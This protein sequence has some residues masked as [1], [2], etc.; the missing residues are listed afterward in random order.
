LDDFTIEETDVTPTAPFEIG[1]TDITATSAD[2]NWTRNAEDFEFKYREKAFFLDDSEEGSEPWTT[3]GLGFWRTLT[4]T[5]GNNVNH[6]TQSTNILYTADQNG[7]VIQT[8]IVPVDTWRVS[9]KVSLTGTLS[10]LA[11]YYNETFDESTDT[12]EVLVSTTVNNNCDA[13]TPIGF[14]SHTTTED[15]FN[16]NYYS[17]SLDSYNGQEGYIAFRHKSHNRSWLILDDIAIYRTTDEWTTLTTT[18]NNVR[19]TGLEPTTDYEFQMRSM[20]FDNPSDWTD[21]KTFTTEDIK[22]LDGKADNAM[23][24][25]AIADG[26]KHDVMIQDYSLSS[27]RGEWNT[28]CLPFDVT[29]FDDTDGITFSGTP[30]EGA[31]VKELTG[32]DFSS[33]VLTMN[34]NEVT[35]VEA[36]KPYIVQWP[37]GADLVI[38]N[39]NEWSTFVARVATGE[40]F[41]GKYVI[42]DGDINAVLM[43]GT[44]EHPFCG[45]FDGNG[46]TLNVNIDQ[47]GVDYAAPFQYIN[48]AT[49]RNVKVTGSVSGGQYCAGIAGKAT[50]GTNSI[51]NCWMSASVTSQGNIGGVLGHGTTSSTTISNCYL[52]GTLNGENIGI[53]CG[54]GY[55]G[56]SHTLNTCWAN[57]TYN[58]NG[59]AVNL[60][61]ADGTT[62]SFNNCQHNDKRISQ[63]TYRYNDLVIILTLEG[64]SNES[65]Y[66]SFLGSQWG[67]N[68]K[69]ELIIRPSAEMLSSNIQNPTFKDVVTNTNSPS[70]L[71]L[72]QGEFGGTY[73]PV[74]SLS[75]VLLD[76][77]NPGN[78][79]F[80]AAYS[81]NRASLGDD[82]VDWYSDATLTSPATVIPFDADGNVTLYA[83]RWVELADDAD[84]SGT[85][86]SIVSTGTQRDRVVL[87]KDRTIYRDDDWNTLCL[88]F[89]MSEAQI[90]A[91][92]LVGVTIMELDG[93]K[94]KLT[95]D[96]KLTLSFKDAF[97]IEAGRPYIV[98]WKQP[99]LVI[100]N[101][102]DWDNFATAVN[103][104]TTYAGKLVKL[105]ASIDA[106]T[107]VGTADHPF[108]GIF[109]GNGYTL[110]L[111][112][113]DSDAD[114]AAPFRY[115]N[116]ATIRNLKVTGS[117]KGGQYCAGIVGAAIDGTNRI[118]NCWMSANV[119]GEN[120]NIGGVLGNGTSSYT[121]ISNC[122]LNSTLNGYG[123]GVFCGGGSAD[124]TLILETCWT[125]GGYNYS[126]NLD[127]S[128]GEINLVKTDGGTT[129]IYNCNHNIE[130]ITQGTYSLL[131]IIGENSNDSSLA[132]FLGNQWT[133]DNSGKLKLRPSA[134]FDDTPIENPKFTGVT[135]VGDDPTPVK[136]SGVKFIGTYSPVILPVGDHYNLF[137]GT[138]NTLFWPSAAHNDANGYKLNSCRAYFNT[139]TSAV[140]EFRLIFGDE[141]YDAQSVED[142][143]LNN[144]NGDGAWYDLSGRKLDGRPTKKGLYI[145]GGRK[146]VVN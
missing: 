71:S 101:A 3:T 88:P 99:T 69:G 139:G 143:R 53:F 36:G 112:I 110:N 138:N 67:L 104:G 133:T 91:S 126:I 66:V 61:T 14:I 82:F 44:P 86:A 72:N 70:T 5:V 39:G 115:I 136:F 15:F 12:C 117:V 22:L 51:R 97:S 114:Y 79:A 50:G 81:Y 75:D 142:V 31:T 59:G 95:A 52:T 33:D 129:I 94:S 121:T 19:L 29:D 124:G 40:T 24:I 87:L 25:A 48:G 60:V 28:L 64:G 32:S 6:V 49:I 123:I 76:A 8:D 116:G 140:R 45:T 89:S 132:N 73:S 125:M 34:F 17:C 21:I 119:T 63:G 68:S 27:K 41:A 100:K 92:P 137:L 55:A 128:G 30:L 35:A 144:E 105:D 18:E 65:Q 93:S 77:H 109:D 113:D 127:G 98:K 103:N 90:E 54:G 23:A 106:S 43:A 38:H 10:F 9:P 20:F 26:K 57:G 80:H 118:R 1:A 62:L 96:G 111:S 108:C 107:M 56:S 74:S 141:E 16:M 47:S 85:I 58:V 84:N 11:R 46:H 135:I 78:G 120:K 146:V 134:V 42:L 4:L 145:H 131:I 102:T 13:F 37:N 7:N 83:G 130:G 122:Y 2:V